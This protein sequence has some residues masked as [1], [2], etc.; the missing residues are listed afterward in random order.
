MSKDGLLFRLVFNP[1][2]LTPT[3]KHKGW[4]SIF[5]LV[6]VILP[7]QNPTPPSQLVGSRSP[8]PPALLPFTP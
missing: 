8:G 5:T 4:L 7:L 2:T 1:I 6:V 3:E